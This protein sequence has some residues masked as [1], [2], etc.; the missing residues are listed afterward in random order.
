[1]SIK[2]CPPKQKTTEKAVTGSELGRK[3]RE[4][5][6]EFRR[7]GLARQR[8]GVR[9]HVPKHRGTENAVFKE[10]Q[11]SSVAI[12]WILGQGVSAG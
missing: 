1:M 6:T 12:P 11:E 3:R 2:V 4:S 9:Q 8:M 5:L 10:K 7:V